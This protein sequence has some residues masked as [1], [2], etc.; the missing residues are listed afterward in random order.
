M[1]WNKKWVAARKIK[2]QKRL[3]AGLCPGCGA[4]INGHRLCDRC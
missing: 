3:D 1:T 2:I 4:E